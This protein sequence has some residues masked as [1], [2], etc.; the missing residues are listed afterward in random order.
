MFYIDTDDYAA[1]GIEVFTFPGGEPH[2]N[3][4]KW[5]TPHVHIFA[6]IRTWAD[7]GT[8]LVVTDA[9]GAQGVQINLFMPYLPGAR[10]DRNPD[11]LTPL[12]PRIYSRALSRVRNLTCCDPHSEEALLAYNQNRTPKVR[13]VDVSLVI[14]DLVKGTKYDFI[15]CPDKGATQRAQNA[16][17][18]LGIKRVLHCEKKRDFETGQLSGFVVPQISGHGL[19]VDDI[20]DG[21]GT[22]VGIRKAYNDRQGTSPNGVTLDLFVTHGI[23]SKGLGVLKDFGHVYTTNSFY[24]PLPGHSAKFTAADLIPYYFGGL[25]P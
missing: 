14:A 12:T 22:F 11:G 24:Q 17:T 1:S 18:R 15:L 8:L 23:F 13:V 20:C 9:L 2:A 16:A 21:G 10:Q 5:T 6:K 19:L 3:V 7:F 25:N 4:P